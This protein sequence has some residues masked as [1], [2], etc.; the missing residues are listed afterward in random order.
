MSK[1]KNILT[2][3]EQRHHVLRYKDKVIPDDDF[4][5]LLY[6]AWKVTPSKNNFMPYTVN[7]LG[8]GDKRKKI[9]Y[10][11]CLVKNFIWWYGIQSSE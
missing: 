4:S 11:T 6:K 2:T 7:V 3:L 10:D 5:K 8:P 1:K 9:I